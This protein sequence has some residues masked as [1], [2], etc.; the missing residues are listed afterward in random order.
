MPQLSPPVSIAINSRSAGADA[1]WRTMQEELDRGDFSW[2][3]TVH[4]QTHPASAKEYAVRGYTAEILDCRDDI[5]HRLHNMPYGQHVF[6]HILTTG[7]VDD[8]ILRCDAGQF[9]FVRGYNGRDNPSS[10]AFTPWNREHGYY[11]VGGL[12]TIDYDRV[13]ARSK[14]AGRF[15]AAG[16]DQLNRGFDAVLKTGGIFYAL[17]HPDRY[18]NSVLYDHAPGVDGRRGST[19]MQH[20]THVADRKNVWYVANGWMYSYRFVAENVGVTAID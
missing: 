5:R 11:G 19:L 13:I 10:V 17:W 8:Q 16:T 15:D 1:M 3:P 20:L 7:Y 2:E 4:G 18:S 14:P 9:L 12:S 6:E